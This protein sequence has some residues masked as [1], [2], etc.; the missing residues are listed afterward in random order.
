MSYRRSLGLSTVL[1][2]S[3][4]IKT[5]NLGAE[6]LLRDAILDGVEGE[7]DGSLSITNTHTLQHKISPKKEV[8]V[9]QVLFLFQNVVP[10]AIPYVHYPQYTRL[11]SKRKKLL[12]E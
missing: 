5:F 12:Q 6:A 1:F 3:P 7:D 4:L 2:G 9:P 8:E 11:T 10:P